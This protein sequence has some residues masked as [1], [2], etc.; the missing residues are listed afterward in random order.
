M[1]VLSASLTRY[2]L[3]RTRLGSRHR[4]VG[5]RGEVFFTCTATPASFTSATSSFRRSCFSGGGRRRQLR[6]AQRR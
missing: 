4:L 2:R 1:P 3:E 6:V 5:H